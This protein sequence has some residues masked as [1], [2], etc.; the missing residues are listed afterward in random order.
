MNAPKK[1]GSRP[2]SVISPHHIE[3]K[4]PTEAALSRQYDPC[5]RQRLQQTGFLERPKVNRLEANLRGQPC[6]SRKPRRPA[7]ST[8][9]GPLSASPI[10]RVPIVL[11]NRL[12]G[13]P[14][15]RR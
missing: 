13:A 1:P 6:G 14:N 7:G 3:R 12:E 5:H 2:A 8:R 4:I 11:R 15:F 10:E 9:K